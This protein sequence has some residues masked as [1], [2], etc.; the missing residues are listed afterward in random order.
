M[1]TPAAV[2]ADAAD[3]AVAADA[4]KLWRRDRGHARAH[5]G[6]NGQQAAAWR[7]QPRHKQ[8]KDWQQAVSHWSSQ[9]HGARRWQPHVGFALASLMHHWL[10]VLP[11]PFGLEPVY[12]YAAYS[13]PSKRQ[14][15]GLA[16]G[17]FDRQCWR[18]PTTTLASGSLWTWSACRLL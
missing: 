10:P 17:D 5:V 1:A 18:S 16:V 13:V 11:R 12:Q 14:Q 15:L 9:R 2:A 8:A 3:V 7:Q 4:L 6:K